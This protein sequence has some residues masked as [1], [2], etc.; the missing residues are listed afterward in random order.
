MNKISKVLLSVFIL[1][2]VS[3]AAFADTVSPTVNI[4]SPVN[5]FTT[6]KNTMDVQV[7]FRAQR[8]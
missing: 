2:L 6:D 7:Y 3:A 5:G 1:V 8:Q 4:L